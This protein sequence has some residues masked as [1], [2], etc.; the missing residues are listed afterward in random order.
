MGCAGAD[1]TVLGCNGCNLSLLYV[2]NSGLTPATTIAMNYIDRPLGS[3]FSTLSDQSYE[4]SFA[5]FR[6]WFEIGQTY[7]QIPP[8][9]IFNT[10]FANRTA[11]SS[12]SN[13][14]Y[15][16]AHLVLRLVNDA[17]SDPILAPHSTRLRNRFGARIL[18]QFFDDD[19]YGVYIDSSIPSRFYVDT[20]LIA[21]YANLGCIEEDTIRNYILQSLISHTK[22]RDHQ[23]I[24]LAI[25]FKI[26]GATF[27][28]YVDPAVVDRC[29]ELFKNRHRDQW[30]G[31]LI[32]VSERV[33]W[34]ETLELRQN[35]RK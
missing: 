21:H 18:Q 7:S 19:L 27:G 11:G 13:S 28:A 33:L 26:A 22:V 30:T 4:K 5:Y 23:V 14:I 31:L 10:I 20:N 15:P 3:V 24:A 16:T 32:Q 35:S 2:T 1:D 8:D 25:L 12:D 29:F 9:L 34:A 6:L 17:E